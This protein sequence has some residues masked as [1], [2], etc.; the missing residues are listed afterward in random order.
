MLNG[1]M[2]LNVVGAYVKQE[3][4][5]FSISGSR[6]FLVGSIQTGPCL[7]SSHSA[8][9]DVLCCHSFPVSS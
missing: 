1:G 4:G 7:R 5:N 3:L 6:I 2:P 9:Q 8:A